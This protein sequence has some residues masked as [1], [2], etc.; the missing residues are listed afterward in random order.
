MY[1]ILFIL[2]SFPSQVAQYYHENKVFLSSLGLLH[3]DIAKDAFRSKLMWF[4]A[5][6]CGLAALVLEYRYHLLTMQ[7]LKWRI[8]RLE[9]AQ[10]QA[11]TNEMVF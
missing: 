1:E 10:A 6:L 3:Y 9:T 11:G 7:S 8:A 5:E 2:S 4:L